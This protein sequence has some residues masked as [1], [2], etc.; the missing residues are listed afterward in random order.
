MIFKC[1][2]LAESDVILYRQ[3]IKKFE[4]EFTFTV[5]QIKHLIVYELEQ[6]KK[7]IGQPSDQSTPPQ[8]KSSIADLKLDS[9]D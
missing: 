5:E 6:S 2:D 7:V 9:N 3:Q 4:V 1:V 8:P